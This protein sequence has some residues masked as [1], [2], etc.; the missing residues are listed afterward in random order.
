MKT[1]THIP[2]SSVA[3]PQMP[4]RGELLAKTVIN[5]ILARPETWDQTTWHSSCGT[6][7]CFAGLCQILSGTAPNE[8]TA[9]LDAQKALGLD[10]HEVAVYFR[11]D[12]HLT[13][14][15]NLAKNFS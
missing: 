1:K 15:Y 3:A 11:G 2:T 13:E 7:H 14:L 4:L 8:A 12:C 6:K 10:D 9:K 5:Q